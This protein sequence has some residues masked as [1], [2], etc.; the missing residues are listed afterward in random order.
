[1]GRRILTRDTGAAI[2]LMV[3]PA[4]ITNDYVGKIILSITNL[5]G[6]KTGTILGLLVTNFQWL[7]QTC[8]NCQT[9]LFGPSS[10]EFEFQFASGFELSA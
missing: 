5:T 2:G 8:D 1:M 9:G 6:G 7:S 10:I 3:S 4:A